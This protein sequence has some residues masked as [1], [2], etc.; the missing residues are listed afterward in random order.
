MQDFWDW[1]WQELA[2]YDLGE[3]IRYIN[4]ITK[5]KVFVVGHSQVSPSYLNRLH[6]N[7]SPNSLVPCLISFRLQGT[8]MSLAAFTQS[9][10]VSMVE[11]AALLCPIT[12]LDHVSAPLVLR[13]VGMHLDQVLAE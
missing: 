12:H 3:T 8:I 9:D 6:L 1:S 10:I 11:A 4:S 13:M 2:L 7:L 5:S